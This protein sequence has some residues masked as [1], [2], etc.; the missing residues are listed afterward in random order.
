MKM[1]AG[2]HAKMTSV[3]TQLFV[4]PTHRPATKVTENLIAPVSFSPMPACHS[5]V[6]SARRLATSPVRFVSCQP[7]SWRSSART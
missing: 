1:S 2:V 3:R 7:A 6:S 5:T 4:K